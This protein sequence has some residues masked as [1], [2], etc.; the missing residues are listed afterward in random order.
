MSMGEAT[1]IIELHENQCAVCLKPYFQKRRGRLRRTCCGACRQ[2]LY[3]MRK[4]ITNPSAAGTGVPGGGEGEDGKAIKR[5]NRVRV[6]RKCPECGTAIQQP[7]RGRKRKT[8]SDRCRKRM[9]RR[10]NPPCLLCRKRFKP[11]RYQGSHLFCSEECRYKARDMKKTE[12]R[13]ERL[14][15]AFRGNRP[16]WLPKPGSGYRQEIAPWAKDEAEAVIRSR[17]ARPVYERVAEVEMPVIEMIDVTQQIEAAKAAV[18]K[19]RRAR[20][21]AWELLE[22]ESLWF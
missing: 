7:E 20:Q 12:K 4:K 18:R 11:E 21:L 5:R 8:C 9:W 2:K 6:A 13:R 15:A 19:A 3:R 17:A 10:L 1:T 14:A 22:D 16:A